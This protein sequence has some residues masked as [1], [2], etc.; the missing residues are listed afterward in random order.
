M[1]FVSPPLSF[2]PEEYE[3][4]FFSQNNETLRLYFNQIDNTLKDALKQEYA[5]S[6]AW[7]MG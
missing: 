1:D 4:G 2:A 7:F 5:E 6:T 3:S